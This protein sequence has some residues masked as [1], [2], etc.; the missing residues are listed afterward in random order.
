MQR[1]ENYSAMILDPNRKSREALNKFL[2]ARMKEILIAGEVDEGLS[3]YAAAKPNLLLADLTRPENQEWLAKARRLHPEGRII[4]ISG[5]EDT[6]TILRHV[7]RNLSG[8]IYKPLAGKQVMEVILGCVDELESCRRH[9][10]QCRSF[11]EIFDAQP[12]PVFL[13][14][15][16]RVL[17]GNRKFLEFFGVENVRELTETMPDFRQSF[18]ARPG[19]L[20]PSGTN[21]L[22]EIGGVPVQRRRV[23]LKSKWEPK[24]RPFL[25]HFA[26]SPLTPGHSIVTLTDL[27][28]MG[29]VSS[30]KENGRDKEENGRKAFLARLETEV[31]RAK[32]YETPMALLALSVQDGNGLI[33]EISGNDYIFSVV[34][35][36]VNGALRPTDAYVRFDHNRF[37]VA[38][39]HTGL[40]DGMRLAERLFRMFNQLEMVRNHGYRFKAGITVYRRGDAHTALLTRGV[41]ALNKAERMEGDAIYQV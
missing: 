37:L 35:R 39:S 2:S 27:E 32:R 41:N 9:Q 34:P 29:H 10:D 26:E 14:D 20:A 19:C 28:Q 11:K 17:G 13:T 1:L 16:R 12:H 38:A 15:G 6:P 3:R 25:V 23:A 30:G 21:W 7:N 31:H 8:F 22:E 4:G 5:K 40:Q 36:V 24:G 33:R 18:A